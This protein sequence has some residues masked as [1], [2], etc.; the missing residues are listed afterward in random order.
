MGSEGMWQGV[1]RLTAFTLPKEE[2]LNG[3]LIPS[4]G[5]LIV[6]Y[7]LVNGVADGLGTRLLLFSAG[8]FLR[9]F[10]F[11]GERV[12]YE[13]VLGERS[14]GHSGGGEVSNEMGSRVV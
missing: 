4:E 12:T 6:H 13:R 10:A 1:R 7:L 9:R 2:D 8:S 3:F 14:G 11:A 5:N